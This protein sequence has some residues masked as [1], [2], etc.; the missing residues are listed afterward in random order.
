MQIY[1]DSRPE[2]QSVVDTIIDRIKAA[3][4]DDKETFFHMRATKARLA[5]AAIALANQTPTRKLY[6]LMSTVD[7][8]INRIDD[9]RYKTINNT[10]V[11][12]TPVMLDHVKA[13][14]ARMNIDILGELEDS[15]V[16]EDGEDIP[17]TMQR[18]NER[19]Y[20]HLI[21]YYLHQTS[22]ETF[23]L[24]LS[25]SS[26]L[27]PTREAIQAKSKAPALKKNHKPEPIPLKQTTTTPNKAANG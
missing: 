7:L 3:R 21:I 15:F 27:H 16:P 26:V 4:A 9:D 20:I 17:Q 5:A 2:F 10:C 1:L 24:M 6:E 18:I 11:H 8:Q 12:L 19:Q 25:G 23:I 22:D 14:M 13:G